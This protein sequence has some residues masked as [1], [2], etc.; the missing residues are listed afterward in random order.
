MTVCEM[1]QEWLDSF[2][3]QSLPDLTL[4][5]I[6]DLLVKVSSRWRRKGTGA[7]PVVVAVADQGPDPVPWRFEVWSEVV[8]VGHVAVRHRSSGAVEKG[9]CVDTGRGERRTRFEAEIDGVSLAAYDRRVSGRYE[10]WQ[11]VLLRFLAQQGELCDMTVSDYITARWGGV[12]QPRQDAPPSR[13]R[14]AGT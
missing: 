13:P 9:L 1:P 12:I 3:G 8:R 7:P 6:G 2:V 14:R 11:R 10:Q 4:D 5:E